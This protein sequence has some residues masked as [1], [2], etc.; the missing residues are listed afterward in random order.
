MAE[1]GTAILLE[2]CEAVMLVTML[3]LQA[4]A[5]FEVR[6]METLEEGRFWLEEPRRGLVWT[7]WDEVHCSS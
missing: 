6:R 5:A 2:H 4:A 7:A 1:P 3:S